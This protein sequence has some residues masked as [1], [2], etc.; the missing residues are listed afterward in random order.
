MNFPAVTAVWK[1]IFIGVFALAFLLGAYTLLRPEK[2][3]EVPREHLVP[4][5]VAL[6][7]AQTTDALVKNMAEAKSFSEDYILATDP[8]SLDSIEA[9][10]D[11]RLAAVDR[12]LERLSGKNDPAMDVL[13]AQLQRLSEDFRRDAK[14]M[15]R[16]HKSTLKKG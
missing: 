11:K 10:F 15:F 13:V 16:Q 9:L 5:L 6:G 1:R 7:E 4:M 14:T 3:V 12:D 8:A 2:P